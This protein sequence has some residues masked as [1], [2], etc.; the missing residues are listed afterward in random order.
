M[1]IE[2]NTRRR[3]KLDNALFI[4]ASF[5]PS[6]NGYFDSSQPI[7]RVEFVRDKYTLLRK[8]KKRHKIKLTGTRCGFSVSKNFYNSVNKGDRVEY[9]VKRGFLGIEWLYKKLVKVV[10]RPE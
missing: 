2:R 6:V 1:N 5:V 9:Y 4:S 7:K 10:E 3:K 8:G